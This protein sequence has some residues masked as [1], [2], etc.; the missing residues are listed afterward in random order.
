[1]SRTITLRGPGMANTDFSMFKSYQMEHFM[2]QFRAEV[3]NL[4]NTP[5]FYGPGT[6]FG[7]S[8]FGKITSQANFPR[9]VQLGIRLAF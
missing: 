9:V 4:T 7:S 2:A 3:F 6:T 8:T 5:Q 1:V